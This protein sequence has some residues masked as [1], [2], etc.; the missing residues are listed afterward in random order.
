MPTQ[1]PNIIFI[2]ADQLAA[3]FVGCYGSGVESTP[4][5]DSLAA[6]GVR[7]DR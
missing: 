5:L 4:T 7:F 1:P 6:R 2:M 3:S